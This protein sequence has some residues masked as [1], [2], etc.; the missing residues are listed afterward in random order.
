MIQVAE[1][2]TNTSKE[3]VHVAGGHSFGSLG[4]FAEV[5]ISNYEHL[6]RILR[7]IFDYKVLVYSISICIVK[8]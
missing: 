1:A 3:W 6:N 7:T 8:Q 2:G 4:R 5:Y